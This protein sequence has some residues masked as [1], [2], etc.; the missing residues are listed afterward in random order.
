MTEAIHFDGISLPVSDVAPSVT[1]YQRFGF[2][3]QIHRANFALLHLGVGSPPYWSARLRRSRG[4]KT[5]RE[6]SLR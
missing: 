1:F 4:D 5:P 2:E 6:D 3:V